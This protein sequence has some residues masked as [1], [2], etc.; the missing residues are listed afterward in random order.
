M[1]GT[2]SDAREL[3][4]IMMVSL[5]FMLVLYILLAAVRGIG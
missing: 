4:N 2:W 1:H 3:R 5:L